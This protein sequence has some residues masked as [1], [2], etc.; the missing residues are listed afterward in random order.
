M[1]VLDSNKWTD[2]QYMRD[3]F[4]YNNTFFEFTK[5]TYLLQLN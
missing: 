5:T 3:I 4:K 2:L 1:T